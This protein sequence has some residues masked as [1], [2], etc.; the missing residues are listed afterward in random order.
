MRNSLF[1]VQDTLFYEH[2]FK[3][4]S[5]QK[6]NTTLSNTLHFFTTGMGNQK[7]ARRKMPTAKKLAEN[8]ADSDS[9]SQR[10]LRRP[11]PKPTGKAATNKASRVIVPT[12]KGT[13]LSVA[14]AENNDV[15]MVN[16]NARPGED[17]V[18]EEDFSSPSWDDLV[19]D[20][21]NGKEVEEEFEEE[22][23]KPKRH[24]PTAQ[25]M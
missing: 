15:S 4:H 13:H 18:I 24:I 3:K 22:F 23:E 16:Y 2:S 10:T 21:H 9:P 20:Y 25:G 17:D 8:N 7:N 14:W 5:F 19:G 1:A 6:S 12:S 11:R